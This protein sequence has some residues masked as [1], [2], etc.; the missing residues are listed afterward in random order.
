MGAVRQSK[1]CRRIMLHTIFVIATAMLGIGNGAAG[2]AI[3]DTFQ[4]THA[5]YNAT[6][7]EKAPGKTYVT[8]SRKMG[9]YSMRTTDVRYKIFDGDRRSLF[10]AEENRVGDFHFLRVRTHSSSHGVL[11]REFEDR[12]HL[13]IKAIGQTNSGSS[14]TATTD[15]IITVL[16]RNDLSPLFY[17]EIYNKS[18]SEDTPLHSSVVQVFA[19][20]S[21]IGINKEIY[22]S[23]RK[24]TRTF[25]I[26]PT[27]GVI[28]LTRPLNVFE[29]NEYHLDVIAEDRGP[30]HPDLKPKNCTVN[31][32]VLEANF[33]APQIIVQHLPAVVENGSKG[34]VYA[35]ITVTDEDQ[36]DKGVI[37]DVSIIDSE[38][39]D[40][41]L[42]RIEETSNPS[43]YN[44]VVLKSLD[45][46]IAP[47]GYDLEIEATDSGIPP[48]SMRTMIHVDILDINDNKPLFEKD[49]YE[50]SVEEL[51]PMGTS[52]LYLKAMDKD[53]GR[54]SEITY[55]IESGNDNK[56]F[57]IH[58]DTGLISTSARLDTETVPVVT[59]V[60]S[61]VDHGHRGSTRKGNTVVNITVIDC[62]D[63]APA[64]NLS[65][66]IILMEENLPVGTQVATITATDADQGGNGRV[67]YSIANINS[68]PFEIDHFTGTIKTTE[69]MDYETMRRI[70]KVKVRASDWGTP[71]RRESEI[72]LDIQLTNIN[73]NIP[74]FEK[75][76]CSGYLSREAP[77]GTELAVITAIDF[78]NDILT[79]RI[80]SGNDD[81]CFDILPT[82]GTLLLNCSMEDEPENEKRVTVVATDGNF[83]SSESSMQI[84][85]VNNRQNSQLSN[86]DAN[87]R[88][89]PTNVSHELAKQVQIM[90]ENNQPLADESTTQLN[91]NPNIYDP[92]FSS[93]QVTILDISEGVEVGTSILTVQADDADPGFNGRLNF[94]ILDG[95]PHNQFDIEPNKGQ[96][97]VIS[98]L[99]RESI[100]KYDL[101]IMAIDQADEGSQRS[102]TI[103]I[104]VNLLDEN[105]NPPIFEE[106]FNE[107]NG[108]NKVH[109]SEN[110]LVNATISQLIA[111]DRDLGVNGKVMYSLGTNINKFSIDAD[112]GIVR[113]AQSLDR[114]EMAVYYLPVVASDKGEKPLSSTT[115]LTIALDDVNDEV[116]K[117]I[118]DH[119][120]LKIRE[121]LPIGT[122]VTIVKAED[123]DQGDNGKVA[124]R[125]TYG[126]EDKFEIDELTGVIRILDSLDF[127]SQQIYNISAVA[128][129][130]GGLVSACFI[131]IEVI[132]VNENLEPPVFSSYCETGFVQE[133][134]PVGVFVLQ[135]S[136]SD[137]D[138]EIDPRNFLT[139]SIRDGSGLGRFTIDNNGTIRTSQILDR[140]T[141]SH[142]W[143]TVYA[144][145][146]APV[147][148][149]AR[150]EVF[151]KVIEVNDNSPQFLHPINYMAIIENSASGLV[152]GNITAHDKDNNPTERL[153]Y[154][155]TKGNTGQYFSINITTGVIFTTEH[156]LDREVKES[157]TLEVTVSDNGTPSLTSV[158]R[159]MVKVL[160]KNDNKP[161]FLQRNYKVNIMAKSPG[162][163]PMPVL[164]VFGDDKD[165][166]KNAQIT[167]KIRG[168][169]QTEFT[170]NA[171]T[172]MI[173]AVEALEPKMYELKIRA[174]DNG[175]VKK[176]SKV[177]A[178]II[179]GP[180]LLSSPN[181]PRFDQSVYLF[182]PVSENCK[183]G[184][185]LGLVTAR[186]PDKD[187]IWFSIIGGD[188]NSDFVISPI[189]GSVHLARYLD[190]ETKEIYNLTVAA[191]DGVY[192]ARANVVLRV[193]DSN[194]NAPMFTQPQFS[195]NVSEN[196]AIG[197]TVLQ[198]SAIDRD[199]NSRLFYTI[200]ATANSITDNKFE[201]N[202]E[203]GV[204]RVNQELDREVQSV[205][206]LTVM[207]R[208][209]GKQSHRNYTYVSIHVLDHN[210]FAPEFLEDVVEGRVFE[211]AAI[212][213]SVVEVMAID[214]D[215]GQNAELSFS[216]TSGNIG[217]MFEIDE[218]LGIITVAQELNRDE[219]SS[220]QL[221]VMATDHGSP[222]L[223]STVSVTILVTISNNAAPKF[224]S[225]MFM[226]EVRENCPLG[227]HV[228]P[229]EALCQSSMLFDIISGNED[230][231]FSINPNSG[232]IYTKDEVDYETRDQYN[233]T[234]SATNIVGA[235]STV[236]VVILVLDLND[237][238]P[239]FDETMCEG[240][241]SESAPVGS[242]ILSMS[243]EPLVVHAT[244]LDSYKNAHVTYKITDP[245]GSRYFS[246]DS[247]T[248]A[249]KSMAALDHEEF[250]KIEFYVYVWD[251][252]YPQLQAVEPAKVV[253]H[254]LDMNDNP[255]Y[256]T[257]PSY[258]ADILLPTTEN[259]E[260][261]KLNATDID[262][263]NIDTLVYSIVD[264][265]ADEKFKINSQTGQI[266]IKNKA[267]L[268]ESYELSVEVTD[269]LFK[270]AS[271]VTISIT[272]PEEEVFVFSKP[273]YS[274]NITENTPGPQTLTVIQVLDPMN[275]HLVFTL[276]NHQDLFSVVLTS[277]VLQTKERSFDREENTLYTLVVSVRGESGQIA[278]VLVEVNI[279]DENDND[280]QFVNQPYDTVVA[281]GLQP[282]E[283]VRQVTAIDR[284]S[285]SNGLVKFTVVTDY[286]DRFNIGT[287]DGRITLTNPLD[288]ADQ[289]RDFVLTIRASDEGIPPRSVD[290]NVT[291]SVI[292]DAHPRFEQQFYTTTVRED[293]QLHTPV[294]SV[295]AVSPNG[296]KL[297][298]TIISGDTYKDF[299]VDFNI[300][301]DVLGPCVVGVVSP[302]D[303]E[304]TKGYELVV[305]AADVKTSATA[306][307]TIRV[308]VTDVND[309]VP[310][311]TNYK[312]T[313]LL[314]EAVGVGM[315]VVK[316]HADDDDLGS[317]G[318]VY[319]SIE[320]L[321]DGSTDPDFFTIDS[322]TGLITLI[323]P[324]D[325]EVQADFTFVVRATD[326]GLPASSSTVYVHVIVEDFNDNAPQFDQP[327]YDCSITVQTTGQI[328]TRVTASDPDISSQ[329][330]LMYA[331]VG[332]NDDQTF[333]MNAQTGLVTLTG[334]N[335][336]NYYHAYTVNVS[337][338]DGVFTSFT[339]VGITIQD[340]NKH[341]PM[342]QEQPY[343]ASV[344]ENL[345][346]GILVT[347]VSANDGDHGNNG[348]LTYTITSDHMMQFFS[349][350]ADTGEIF[351]EHMFDREVEDTYL[352]PV[353][354]IDNGGRMGFTMVEISITDKNDNIP[355]F[356]AQ[357]YR[358]VEAYDAA[359]NTTI[360]QVTARDRDLGDNGRIVYQLHDDNVAQY[361]FVDPNTGDVK[362]KAD[363]TPKMHSVMQFFISAVDFGEIPLENNVPVEIYV[364]GPEEVAPRFPQPKYI[365]V[366]P[367]NTD[368]FNFI[369]TI[370]AESQQPVH[371][372]VVPGSNPETNHPQ[373]FTVDDSGNIHLNGDLDAE[374]VSQYT[375]TMLA[376]TEA[377]PS[378]V[379]HTEVY[380]QITGI[381]DNAPQFESNP[382]TASLVE[383]SK[384]GIRIIQ[385]RAFDLDKPETLTYRF[386]DGMEEI[387]Q[388]FNIDQDTGWIM[389]LSSVDR[390][391]KSNYNLSVTVEDTEG[392]ITKTSVTSVLIEVKDY[393]DN[394]P[395][396]QSRHYQ[397]AVNELAEPGTVLLPLHV[398]DADSEQNTH[399][400]YFIIDGDPHGRFQVYH[401]GE[402]CVSRP[403]DREKVTTYNL[404]IAA[405][406][407]G[408]SSMTT[409]TVDI[410]DDNDNSP[411]CG[412]PYHEV[413]LSED[414]LPSDII[415]RVHAT[416]A[417]D[418]STINAKVRYLLSREQDR[419]KFTVDE[420]TGILTIRDSLDREE[421]AK[422]DVVVSAV[423]GGQRSCDT[424]VFIQLS[425]VN[426]NR[427][428]FVDAPTDFLLSE[429]A[430]IN[431]LLLRVTAQDADLGINRQ[432]K[433]RLTD[434]G[435]GTFAVDSE[436]GILMLKARVD[437][438]MVPSYRLVLQA[439][440]QGT[441]SLSSETVLRVLLQDE[442]DN[443]PEFVR[444][445]YSETLEENVK[446]GTWVT[447]VQATS[448]DI[449]QNAVMTYS[450]VGGNKQEKFSLNPDTGSI[451]VLGELDFEATHQYILTI[452][453]RDHGV[454]PLSSSAYVTINVTDVNDNTPAFTQASYSVRV[455]ESEK[456]A[457]IVVKVSASDADSPPN[458]VLSYSISDGDR[459][460]NFE[461]NP[462]DGTIRIKTPLDRESLSRIVLMVKAKD[463][464]Q[465]SLTAEASVQ[466]DIIDANDCAPRFSEDNYTAIVQRPPQGL[467]DIHIGYDI[468]GF[469]VTDDDLH[470]NGEPFTFDIVNGNEG[471]EFRI[472]S[473]GVLTT[474]SKFNHNI[475][476]LYQ[477]VLRV[478]DN[479]YPSLY[480][481]VP[482]T[483]TVTE[484]GSHPPQVA[485][486]EVTINSYLDTFP[487][488]LIGRLEATDMDRFDIL[489]YEVVS[490]NRHLFDI[491]KDDGRLVAYEGLDA[492]DY[493]V[494]I[495]V[496]DGHY[497]SYGRVYVDV[498]A[499]TEKMLNNAVTIQFQNLTPRDFIQHFQNDFRKAVRK[500]LGI[501]KRDVQ[502]INVQASQPLDGQNRRR[503]EAGSDLDVLFAARRGPNSY[504]SS[505]LLRKKI[506]QITGDIEQALG[507]TVIDV[508]NDIC[509]SD[510]CPDG[511]CVGELVFDKKSQTPIVMDVGTFVTA[512][513]SYTHKCVCTDQ[514]RGPS[515]ENPRVGS[516]CLPG[517]PCITES[518]EPEICT[519]F[520][521]YS[522]NKPMTFMGQSY[523]KWTLQ[524]A[525]SIE[526]RLSLSLRIKTRRSTANIMFAK[527]NVDYSILE[528]FNGMVQ[529]QF[530]CGSGR[531]LVQI[532]VHVNDG[533]WHTISLERR[534]RMA[535]VSLD[536]E[537]SNMDIA[538]GV[539]DYINLNTKDVYFGAEV[540]AQGYR[541][542]VQRGFEG[543][544]EDVKLWSVRLPFEGSNA[545][546]T[547]QEFKQV[548][549]HCKDS[550]SGIDGTNICSTFPC[551]N[552]GTCQNSGINSY[553]CVCPDRYYGAKCEIDSDPC[554]NSPCRNNAKCQNIKD[555]PNEFECSCPGELKGKLC[556]YGQHCIPNPCQHGGTC[557]EGP[558]RAICI[559][560]TGFEGP[561]CTT[562]VN[563]CRNNPCLHG[564]LCHNIEA[565]Y[566]C[567]CTSTRNGDNCQNIIVPEITSNAAG[568]TQE[569][570]FGIVGVAV[571]LIL[572]AFLFVMIQCYRRRNNRRR[573]HGN[574][575]NSEERDMMLRGM[576]DDK[577]CKVSSFDLPSLHMQNIPPSPRPPPVPNRPVS[578]T[579]SNHADSLN[580][581][582]NFDTVRNYGSAADDLE[583][584]HTNIPY[585]D[586]YFQTFAP[587]PPR[588]TA[589][590][591]PSLPPP[592]PSNPPSD[593]DSIQKVPWE[594]EFPNM[595]ENHEEK[596]HPE[597]FS[598]I[599]RYAHPMGP[600]ATS[601]SS[602]PVSESEDEPAARRKKNKDYHWDASDWAPRPSLPNISEVPMKEVPDSP[603]SSPHSNDSNTHVSSFIQPPP[604]MTESGGMYTDPELLE[605]EYVGDSEYAENE[606]DTDD[607]GYPSPPDYHQILGLPPF[608]EI[609]EQGGGQEDPY[610]L[611]QHNLHM[612]PD[613]Y[614][615]NHSFSQSHE[616]VG[617]TGNDPPT[618]P[619]VEV[620]DVS[621]TEDNESV[622]QYGFPSSSMGRR[623]R[624]Q[625]G[626]YNP[627]YG[628]SAASMIDN[629]SV[630]VGGYTSTNASCS[631]ISGLCEIEDSEVNLSEDDSADELT[632]LN[633]EQLHTVV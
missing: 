75:M 401:T 273:V 33:H 242:V 608:P 261:I 600:D 106:G 252:G 474:A 35:I 260:I 308:I 357:D 188:D 430:E 379:S 320:P 432:V 126:T 211:T 263:I 228:V 471:G 424:Q 369:R 403:L 481:D 371:Y 226:A 597:K 581:L 195:A 408:L 63:N 194:D 129:D 282:G 346:P 349:I 37:S 618:Y 210:D 417:D 504:Y 583:N 463:G 199:K 118:P 478:F 455:N 303:Y 549:F 189:D 160:D 572:L 574:R 330:N 475:R 148:Q 13:K 532:P 184:Q 231:V 103:L 509:H 297:I 416:D 377:S 203:T 172:G 87:V 93:T 191:T 487:G 221:T 373:L 17:P 606:Y 551:M 219:M 443:P 70:Y 65:D 383:N 137:A 289:N 290:V 175:D 390:E 460:D 420:T 442:N 524:D 151:V 434:D 286:Q 419:E 389:L 585:H 354:A 246:V 544:M 257:Q 258:H 278:H 144:Q 217:R 24:R 158:T 352:V 325:H 166:G 579:P 207:V 111:H 313:A 107:I 130:G 9:I 7:Y 272:S 344:D 628:Q 41:S 3:D 132:D 38:N 466:V 108:N 91:I 60:V 399:I 212:G 358:A 611:P 167:Y 578:Y 254:I 372:R 95:D 550:S 142:Y 57:T 225:A 89:Q 593:T 241:I 43:E 353:A 123:P 201:I 99:D 522:G 157:H 5:T 547:S 631:D 537:F 491:D 431:T 74:R 307:A 482:V 1:W 264:G 180:R 281:L 493:L 511:K 59:L 30:K 250:D 256:F 411:V 168:R 338:S 556:E 433:Y 446:P 362:V 249:I 109:I 536:G 440:D 415:T 8:S 386:S 298:Y 234:V 73:D 164:R 341:T 342:F 394:P 584:C 576:K 406:D 594:N 331:I 82:T 605:S 335:G 451:Y 571:A 621:D 71:F 422:Y 182:E 296:H 96:L 633:T 410:L 310:V 112:S 262:S 116:P 23:F 248:G 409:V 179:V 127:E 16:D 26:H 122:V 528:I 540:V 235:T 564:G 192:E 378:L 181:A 595:L 174:T 423:D 380:F 150:L 139:Y 494:N 367:E 6:I 454:V 489:T 391:V 405:T 517:Q 28:T 607:H 505:K 521:C 321:S 145:E 51:Y 393:N 269:G 458:S 176:R 251:K 520:S 625:E 133:N 128:E 617:E 224:V 374:D 230:E 465:P 387:S 68:V 414:V 80:E 268:L 496:T 598:G 368:K 527:G 472:D 351:T 624:A 327:S 66:S 247:A 589:S 523:A 36:G 467:E 159:V 283:L 97:T 56:L 72:T 100:P 468:I 565:T 300:G 318:L 533:K 213:T 124:Y 55:A 426:D 243:L 370:T 326:G 232:I 502:I 279:M 483:I 302:L 375:L 58:K 499:I 546:V 619:E 441:P 163:K 12:Y 20:D 229:V 236:R 170:I 141:A 356:T 61:A 193:L 488:G 110:I 284:D 271:T 50:A 359:I 376:Y 304:V 117:F 270:S 545:V 237:N 309:N 484:K 147:P 295:R 40:Q 216:I 566:I 227:S 476:S 495:S 339:R 208:D 101:E 452:V 83:V 610:H 623:P 177:R 510:L 267:D 429:S 288:Q 220:Y 19:L 259:V 437:R 613:Q 599:P 485:N 165:T 277:G 562:R 25:A 453:A 155:I 52:V 149:H 396:F 21:D 238:A 421:V 138:S 198:V 498:V 319:Y 450:I 449:G 588:S 173:Y 515:C 428:E 121:D 569:T 171:T 94:V 587:P 119:Y 397:A 76:Q 222:P 86:S 445:S 516:Q 332:G 552:G 245:K 398:F 543:C 2:I 62:N 85:L 590:M 233:L 366:A 473:Q 542:T 239:V 526:Q 287:N 531:G 64:F 276:L 612:H 131:N 457:S 337:V 265:N 582:N 586:H 412:Q 162:S 14:L 197:T 186:D 67:S 140:E 381:N 444:N 280:P 438:E 447:Q 627:D 244:D 10:K 512:R 169:E 185:M 407:G 49:Q 427:P 348:L 570:L 573:G 418:A 539:N 470:P 18:V 218:T 400:S 266:F 209:Q 629:M 205:H 343:H 113:I 334:R 255:P 604:C 568:I 507:V 425:D 350:D 316:V 134:R 567:N 336:D 15:L 602:L 630:S 294:I 315:S 136:A 34:T 48:K 92:T 518:T 519:D 190:R 490:Q 115:T 614:L 538:P 365:F 146:H 363:L 508:F 153:T 355:A 626:E 632:P 84:T 601:F 577:K 435:N 503:R 480:T 104:S 81:G 323:Q 285:D 305:Q 609:D 183:L 90:R 317:S 312:Y 39:V 448:K 392:S 615:P 324:L 299:D 143:L 47:D 462:K 558:N 479:G 514:S 125:L 214:K 456:V 469:L 314:S 436:T 553:I 29:E 559:C 575:H 306:T 293:V 395:V 384:P 253:I 345:G 561:L 560:Q 555:M 563:P 78:D 529:Y 274:V 54:N 46:E 541:H 385:V 492:G 187:R 347:T 622:V 204:I 206:Q 27:T 88:C 439:S 580:T 77:I 200:L 513:H 42:F 360:I 311:F 135:V 4:F 535:E 596:K 322:H 32:E 161:K 497:I 486:L 620:S 291:I 461:I 114:E 530:D 11:N 292:S 388:V 534:G 557:V 301:T 154:S 364:M 69:R 329:G 178:Q 525:F 333:H 240:K 459:L 603:R 196:A 152:V 413:V 53:F 500:R 501:K 105:D 361:V 404:Q 156:T 506:M 102:S 31:I 79:Y 45:K 120:D 275:Q 382:Y 44:L 548:Q 98:K 591:A 328:V 554:A 340:G 202:S 477:L 223:S 616:Q 464:G 402:V 592:P 215:K 22:Y